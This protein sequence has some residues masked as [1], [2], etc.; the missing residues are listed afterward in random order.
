VRFGFVANQSSTLPALL[1]AARHP[2]QVERLV[3]VNGS[4]AGEIFFRRPRY[5]RC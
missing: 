5:R 3:I 1:Y 2:E 4:P